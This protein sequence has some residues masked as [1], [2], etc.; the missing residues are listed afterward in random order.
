MVVSLKKI[1]TFYAGPSRDGTLGTCPLNLPYPPIMTRT[2]LGELIKRSLRQTWGNTTLTTFNY[3]Y[4]NTNFDINRLRLL[5]HWSVLT[6]FTCI[7]SRGCRF[8]ILTVRKI[9]TLNYWNYTAATSHNFDT[10]LCIREVN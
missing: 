9:K 3:N 6:W 7:H 1:F 10:R 8:G 2:P 4:I 5:L